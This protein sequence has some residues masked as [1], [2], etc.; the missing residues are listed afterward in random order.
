M[1]LLLSKRSVHHTAQTVCCHDNN[2]PYDSREL[3]FIQHPNVPVLGAKCFLSLSTFNPH[4]GPMRRDWL[5]LL[6]T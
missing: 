5:S 3:P 1:F 2:N 4:D 6:S